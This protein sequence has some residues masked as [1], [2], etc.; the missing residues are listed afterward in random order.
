[1]NLWQAR[2]VCPELILVTGNN[3]L[4]TDTSKRIV[5]L[6]HDFTPL[7]E[8]F[9]IDELMRPLSYTVN[10]FEPH[11]ELTLFDRATGRIWQKGG[12]RFP[13]TLEQARSYIDWLNEEAFAEIRTWRLPTTCELLTLINPPPKDRDYCLSP[14]FPD[15]QKWLWSCDHCTFITGWYVNLELGFA[16]Y[17][18]LTSYYHVKA[19]AEEPRI[20]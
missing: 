16:G 10:R 11:T 6:F 17:N 8:V 19:V 7:V 5:K 18:D 9:S 20:G 1:M 2:N 14:V 13:V 4:Y 3:R 15:H 12:T